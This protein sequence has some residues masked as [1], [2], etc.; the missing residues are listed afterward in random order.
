MEG[1]VL[2]GRRKLLE[3]ARKRSDFLA[4][5]TPIETHRNSGNA[6]RPRN[7]HYLYLF[8]G[9][10]VRRQTSRARRSAEYHAWSVSRQVLM[11]D[12]KA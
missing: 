8:K 12:S 2:S 1:K 6:D 9:M 7:P 4:T 3:D 10:G 5:Q 11:I